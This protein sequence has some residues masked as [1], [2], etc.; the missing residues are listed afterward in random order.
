MNPN[1]AE[2]TDLKTPNTEKVIEVAIAD[3]PIYCPGHEMS[4]WNSHPRVFIP[5]YKEGDE[6]RCPYCGT[7]Y[8]V[9]G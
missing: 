3:L 7:I 2:A 9:K 4:L 8:R 6:A 1:T 5:V